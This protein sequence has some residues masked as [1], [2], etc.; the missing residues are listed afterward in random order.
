MSRR[1]C[2]CVGLGLTCS[3]RGPPC[4][5]ARLPPRHPGRSLSDKRL[6]F[7]TSGATIT[8]WDYGGSQR[9]KVHAFKWAARL[10]QPG[11]WC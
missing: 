11:S 7:A 3:L 5:A 10:R 9:D 6:L 4:H 1:G 2:A 8:S